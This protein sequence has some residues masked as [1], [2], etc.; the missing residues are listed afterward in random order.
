MKIASVQFFR[1]KTMKRSAKPM[2]L[3]VIVLAFTAQ[4]AP[5]ATIPPNDLPRLAGQTVEGHHW[6]YTDIV[7][8]WGFKEGTEQL[9]FD[10]SIE[11]TYRLGIIGKAKPVDGDGVTM[12]TGE[13]A[14]KSAGSA[15]LRRGII[16]GVLYTDALRGPA[17]HDRHGANKRW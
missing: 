5:T 10:G 15:R 17:R 4:P 1:G 12:M 2:S 14:W 9:A 8:E 3:A 13:R 7:V 16:V 6:K 11:S